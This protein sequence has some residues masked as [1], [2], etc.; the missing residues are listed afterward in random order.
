MAETRLRLLQGVLN[1]RVSSLELALWICHSTCVKTSQSRLSGQD[2]SFF[3]ELNWLYVK[4]LRGGVP[5]EVPWDE[6]SCWG[7]VMRD[8][9]RTA[10]FTR[11][12]WPRN[13]SS[14][15]AAEHLADFLTVQMSKNWNNSPPVRFQSET[16]PSHGLV[17][18]AV[19]VDF[20]STLRTDAIKQS[21]VLCEVQKPCL[22]DVTSMVDVM[23]LL[24]LFTKPISRHVIIIND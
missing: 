14:A 3:L 21:E 18:A 23:P 1:I 7:S 15:R 24:R 20:T 13:F 2:F 5:T 16:F 22:V 12:D 8:G 6:L 9:W 19:K 17:L 10:E 11:R 4:D